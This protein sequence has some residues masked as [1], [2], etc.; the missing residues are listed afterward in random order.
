SGDY[1]DEEYVLTTSKEQTRRMLYAQYPPKEVIDRS[2]VML[3]FDTDTNAK[4]N[5]MWINVRCFNAKRI[6]VWFY[7]LLG[8]LLGG[9]IFV[10]IRTK[11]KN[12]M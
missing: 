10:V 7:C 2:A 9:G 12:R 6:P 11:I 5:R 4:V 3:Y 1:D 8:V